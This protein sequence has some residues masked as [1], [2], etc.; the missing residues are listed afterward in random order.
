MYAA[1][2]I[3][4]FL[5]LI[6]FLFGWFKQSDKL[7][8]LIYSLSFFVVAIYLFRNSSKTI[9][10]LLLTVM[11]CCW[12]LRLGGYLFW[13]INKMKK[14]TRFDERR[15][16]FTRLMNFWLL[17]TGSIII[18]LI[19]AIIFYSKP[20]V[21]LHI[22]QLVAFVIWLFGFII[23][24]V[25]DFQKSSFKSKPS[26]K[27]QFIQTGLWSIVRYPNYTGEILCWI[28]VFLF[29]SPVFI[30]GNWIAVISPI[31]IIILLVFISGIPLLEKSSQKK[32]GSMS[33]FK[34]YVAG[35]KKLIP[36][37]F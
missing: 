1:S 6:G 20:N 2:I 29:C 8:D 11:I 10:A 24:S 34:K 7:T 31:W 23:E 32:Y 37:I 16:S 27:G 15:V 22:I 17:Q 13:R 21:E 30:T 5:N 35:T 12:A 25:A 9:T 19:P 3:T 33:A 18:I 26:N 28:G 4:I 14:D 36:G